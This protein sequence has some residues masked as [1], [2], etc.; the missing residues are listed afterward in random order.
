MEI[1]QILVIILAVYL[2]IKVIFN[3]KREQLSLG[4]FIFWE[5]TWLL[6]VV[7]TVFY[8]V[9]DG[10][11]NKIGVSSILNLIVYL[12]I[13]MLFVLV[14]K[15]YVKTEEQK[16]EITKL[17]RELAINEKENKK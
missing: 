3:F 14:Y 16:E 9:F 17:V 13:I 4:E 2:I 7:F 8:R 1:I 5:L 15:L 12:G 6:L 10:F 11:A